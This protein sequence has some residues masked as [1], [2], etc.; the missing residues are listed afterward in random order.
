M[1]F[2]FTIADICQSFFCTN[3]S[4]CMIYEKIIQSM[5]ME[6]H[7]LEFGGDDKIMDNIC[8]FLAVNNQRW[9]Q[10]E[11]WIRWRFEQ[12]PSGKAIVVCAFENEHM[13]AC[14][15]IER[16]HVETGDAELNFGCVTSVAIND[17]YETCGV[18]AGILDV[19]EREAKHHSLDIIV[20]YGVD[21]E[22]M[23]REGK[24]WI[25]DS[26]EIQNVIM[27]LRPFRS[28]FRLSGI[29][30]AFVPNRCFAYHPVGLEMIH[31]DELANLIEKP[32]GLVLSYDML[33]WILTF[34]D[35]E[36]LFIDNDD[37]VAIG[38]VG[39]RGMQKEVHL[40]MMVSKNKSVHPCIYQKKLL[41]AIRVKINP[42]EVSATE[43]T[44]VLTEKGQLKGL[45]HVEYAYKVLRNGA[46]RVEEIARAIYQWI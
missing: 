17:E 22:R 13:V 29:K 40:L 11:K 6:Y 16:F 8:H 23:G 43:E 20:V 42:D 28:I 9:S 39:Q 14:L 31:F 46:D 30:K 24:S 38:A 36:Y 7:V 19:A 15:T 34:T 1:I 45:T 10:S 35:R 18:M 32:D 3:L 41:E 2:Y 37:F 25:L 44:H 12:N 5:L 27:P 26:V 4:L 21:A 33:Q